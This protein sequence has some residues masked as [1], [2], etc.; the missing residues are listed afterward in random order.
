MALILHITSRSH[1]QKAQQYGV[2]LA[3]SL[4][5]EGFIHCSTPAQVVATAN[6]F[7]RGQAGLVLLCIE[8]DRVQSE[9]RYEAVNGELFP[10]LYGALN[11][12]AVTQAIDFEPNADGNF[13]L[14]SVLQRILQ[15]LGEDIN[16]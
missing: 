10:H 11:L 13:T 8:S 16:L 2:Y 9:I 7:F 12:D 14:P 6:R 15:E 5:I 4:E 1:W 3:G